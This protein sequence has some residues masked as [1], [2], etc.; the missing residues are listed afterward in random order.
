MFGATAIAAWLMGGSLL[1]L[2]VGRFLRLSEASDGPHPS[3]TS[4]PATSDRRRWG[5]RPIEKRVVLLLESEGRTTCADGV[6]VD[7]SEGGARVRTGIRLTIGESIDLVVRAGADQ[8]VRSDVA[9][10]SRKGSEEFG[11]AGLHFGRS[12]EL[13]YALLAA[14][15]TFCA[16][17]SYCA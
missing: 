10:V 1:G 3:P 2:L 4:A 8:V 9:W 11:E 17:G 5:R 15:S 16:V 14:G 7:L 13:L 6:T 12:T